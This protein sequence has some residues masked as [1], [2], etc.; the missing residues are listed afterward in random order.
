MKDKITLLYNGNEHEFPL[1]KGSENELAI[2]I[3]TQVLAL[4]IL[5]FLMVKMEF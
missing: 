5:H 1:I 4:V 2:D 3:K